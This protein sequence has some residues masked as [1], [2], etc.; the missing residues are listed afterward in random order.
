LAASVSVLQ[1]L[2]VPTDRSF[3]LEVVRRGW[4]TRA[5]AEEYLAD[6][7][8]RTR[9]GEP[10]KHAS[11][12]MLARGG[13]TREQAQSI[14]GPLPGGWLKRARDRWTPIGRAGDSILIYRVE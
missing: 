7:E 9:R 13:V 11:E 1:G 10:V 6:R 5:R 8:A 12:W 3:A 4:V 2:F 14:E